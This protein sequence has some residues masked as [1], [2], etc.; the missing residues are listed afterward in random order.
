MDISNYF[1]IKPN[2]NIIFETQL[3]TRV[4]DITPFNEGEWRS[5]KKFSIKYNQ[6]ADTDGAQGGNDG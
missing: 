4:L 3:I 2:L 1:G 5:Q 6:T